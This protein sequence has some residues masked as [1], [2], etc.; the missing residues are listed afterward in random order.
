MSSTKIS[1]DTDGMYGDSSDNESVLEIP[2]KS[3]APKVKKNYVMTEKRRLNCEKM[4][5]ARNI[6]VEKRTPST[7]SSSTMLCFVILWM[8][9]SPHTILEKYLEF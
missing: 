5:E 3:T 4:T 6:N 9:K 8:I 2:K 1:K 7:A